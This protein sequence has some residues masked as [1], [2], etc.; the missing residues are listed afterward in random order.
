MNSTIIKQSKELIGLALVAVFI[1]L[2]IFL[3]YNAFQKEITIPKEWLNVNTIFLSI[4]I[5]AIP[6]IL[7]GV[8]VSSLIQ[9]FVSEE[10]LKKYIP[11]NAIVAVLPAALLGAIFPVCE[12]AIVPVVR[13][14]I[15][16][17]MP[18]HVAFVF[19]A[20]AP[21]LN[22]V[23]AASTYFAFKS[24]TSILIGR[25]GLAFVLSMVIG[26][27]LYAF[28]KNSNQLKVTSEELVGKQ[29][30]MTQ[31]LNV[32]R[33]KATLYHAS[34]EF[35]DMGKYLIIG[36]FIASL[37]QTFLDRNVLLSMGSNEFTSPLVMMGFAFILSLCSEA[38]A[39]VAAS[40]GN[41][42]APGA[43]L[44]FLV[45]GPMLDLKNTIMLFAYF[46][47]KFVLGFILVATAVVYIGVIIYQSVVL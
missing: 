8:F 16:K 32:N 29:T 13:R 47:L 15:K 11:K 34:D 19:L 38:D 45:Y 12:C 5:E 27:V 44:A 41:T 7:L 3:D 14:L 46:R 30:S 23:V 6:F 37:F 22:P 20:C 25:M 40:F 9:I 10:T 33:W 39:F 21:I 36:A 43:L 18:L 28:F 35:F 31:T 24:N 4:V 26:L 17:G 2:F 42:F 1:Y